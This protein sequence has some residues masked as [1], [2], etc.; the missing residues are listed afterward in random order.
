LELKTQKSKL[1]TQNK[2]LDSKFRLLG[3]WNSKPR[4][5]NPKPKKQNLDSKFRVLGF[6]EL[7]TQKSK[8]KTQKKTS[9][10]KV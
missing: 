10:F 3:F 6:W 1:K 4:N 2:I 8:L 5:Q 7:K 9:S